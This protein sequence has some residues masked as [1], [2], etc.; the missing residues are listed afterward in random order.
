MGRTEFR[1]FTPSRA[2]LDRSYMRRTQGF[3]RRRKAPTNRQTRSRRYRRAVP[4]RA[5]SGRLLRVGLFETRNLR[6][7]GRREAVK[8]VQATGRDRG[9]WWDVSMEFGGAVQNPSRPA[10]HESRDQDLIDHRV[11]I[12]PGSQWSTSMANGD[13]LS[14]SR[15]HHSP[16]RGK[17]SRANQSVNQKFAWPTLERQAGARAEFQPVAGIPARCS[18]SEAAARDQLPC[19]EVSCAR[20]RA[21]R[22]RRPARSRS[23]RA[24]PRTSRGARDYRGNVLVRAR[25]ERRSKTCLHRLIV[26]KEPEIHDEV[27]DPFDN[28]DSGRIRTCRTGST[29][30]PIHRDKVTAPNGF[31]KNT[32]G[33]G[34]G[35]T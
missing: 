18:V 12:S 13:G 17:I 19:R 30:N 16:V 28:I 26:N 11:V 21:A 15:D 27:S 33:L 6:E 35:S 1:K 25:A 32:A 23:V 34:C 4:T 24:R 22:C 9:K 14:A 8:F 20:C 5:T 7:A 31:R 10:L 29:S 3:V 2:R